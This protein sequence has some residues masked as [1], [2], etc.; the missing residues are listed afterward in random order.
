MRAF[1]RNSKNSGWP[2]HP[3]ETAAE[4][5]FSLADK[6]WIILLKSVQI[7]R[8]REREERSKKG[9]V[10]GKKRQKKERERKR[11]AKY[12]HLNG[13][14]IRW[15][16]SREREVSNFRVGF[17]RSRTFSFLLAELYYLIRSIPLL[18]LF[19]H[20]LTHSMMMIPLLAYALNCSLIHSL[21]FSLIHIYVIINLNCCS[22]YIYNIV[23]WI[24]ILCYKLY[25]PS[26]C[27]R[28]LSPEEPNES[29]RFSLFFDFLPPLL[30]LS[31]NHSFSPSLSSLKTRSSS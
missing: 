13:K 3:D 25:L 23:V 1:T 17:Q 15:F 5:I 9:W 19:P 14:I 30:S 29:L 26:L 16:L 24:K 4:K 27:F 21:I 10:N 8:E 20:S 28:I 12:P 6:Y 7:K 11:S 18:P 31:H 22:Y 2:I